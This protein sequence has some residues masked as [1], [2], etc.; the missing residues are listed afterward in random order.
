ML[1][2]AS[3]ACELEWWVCCLGCQSVDIVTL[4]CSLFVCLFVCCLLI[5]VNW[6]VWIKWWSYWLIL[7]KILVQ[8]F[9]WCTNYPDISCSSSVPLYIYWT[10]I[11]HNPWLL[12]SASLPIL[13]SLIVS[14]SMPYMMRHWELLNK[15]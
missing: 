15:P 10:S 12:P 5:L 14:H 2:I 3:Y 7:W 13:Y 1:W 9:Y 4:V 8:I 11:S 6:A